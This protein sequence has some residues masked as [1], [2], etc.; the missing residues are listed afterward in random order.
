MPLAP[1]AE[2]ARWLPGRHEDRVTFILHR[3]EEQ[4]KLLG[5]QLPGG[6][7]PSLIKAQLGTRLWPGWGFAVY[8]DEA[9]AGAGAAVG[10]A[11]LDL[12]SFWLLIAGNL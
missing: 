7:E 2:P 11:V 1:S 9:R 12:P 10:A 8:L 6:T 5:K 4:L 3:A